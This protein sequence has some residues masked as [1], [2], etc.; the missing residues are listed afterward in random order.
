MCDN[1]QSVT[2]HFLFVI[3]R[4]AVEVV[5]FVI[6]LL[7]SSAVKLMLDATEIC[8]SA[9]CEKRDSMQLD[10]LGYVSV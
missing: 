9:S 3:I 5:T 10:Q 2:V 4:C 1:S 6:N 8:V 7:D